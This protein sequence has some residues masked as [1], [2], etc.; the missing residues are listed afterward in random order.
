MLIYCHHCG[1]QISN[2]ATS[3]PHCGAPQRRGG[4]KSRNSAAILAFVL[5][6]IGLHKFYLGRTWQGVLY[7]LFFWTLIP[8]IIA[9]VEGILYLFMDDLDFDSKYNR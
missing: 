4:R 2:E 8:A 3:C 1:K 5:G 6:G 7:L 9:F